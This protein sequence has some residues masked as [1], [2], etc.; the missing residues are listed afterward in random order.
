MDILY[1]DKDIIACIKPVGMDAEHDVP[2][3]DYACSIASY[4]L[5]VNVTRRYM[6]VD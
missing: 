3:E 4:R 6:N 1:S 2:E 5:S